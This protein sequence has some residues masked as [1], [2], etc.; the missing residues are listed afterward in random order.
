MATNISALKET[1][2]R[3]NTDFRELYNSHKELENVLDGFNSRPYLSNS[4]EMKVAELK[5]KKLFLK[6][7]MHTFMQSYQA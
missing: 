1:L 4:D 6:D 3:E 7:K 5:K 2:A